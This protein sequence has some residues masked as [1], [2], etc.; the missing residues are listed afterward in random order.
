MIARDVSKF[1]GHIACDPH[2]KS[3][4]VIP[5]LKDGEVKAVIDIDSYETNNF[6]EVDK[7]YLKDVAD[8]CSKL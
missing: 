7:K 1:S 3:E 5:I 2:S 8:I 4:I 6:S